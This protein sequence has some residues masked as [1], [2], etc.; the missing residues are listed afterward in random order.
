VTGFLIAI[1]NAIDAVIKRRTDA[2]KDAPVKGAKRI[3]TTGHI[4]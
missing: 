1:K 3:R 4:S 2:Q